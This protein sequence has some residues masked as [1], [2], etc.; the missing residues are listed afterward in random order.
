MKRLSKG[1]VDG[2]LEH[3]IL[4]K[5]GHFKQTMN[6][7]K[8]SL[9][10]MDRRSAISWRQTF[11]DHYE[12][13]SVILDFR[14]CVLS[15]NTAFEKMFDCTQTDLLGKPLIF[16]FKNLQV[17]FYKV[18]QNVLNGKKIVCQQLLRK[19]KNEDQ[20]FPAKLMISPVFSSD[21]EIKGILLII[22]DQTEID[23]SKTFIE[24]QKEIPETEENMLHDITKHIDELIILFDLEKDKILYTSPAFKR[25]F[26]IDL[27]TLYNKPILLCKRFNIENLKQLSRFFK[28]RNNGHRTLEFKATDRKTNKLRWF[29]F[30]I[31]PILE[32]DGTVKKHISILRD[33][34]ELKEKNNQ[35]KQLDQ[36]GAIGQMAAGI[37]H[38]I[39]NPLTT[40]KGFVQLLSEKAE[41]EYSD[42]IL[43][44][45]ERIEF[46]M[47]EILMLAKP[48]T[49]ISFKR[50]NL[51]QIIL[52]VISF[53]NPEAIIHNVTLNRSL[54]PIP[55][56]S[57]EAKQIKQVLINI[58]KNAIEAM[59]SG[60]NIRI[61]TYYSDGFIGMDI[62]DN[63]KGIS[64]ERLKRLKE[65]FY[66]DKEKGTGLGL[67][68]CYKLIEDH[69]GT[70]H[71]TS[72]EGRGT[73]VH[74]KLPAAT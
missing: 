19:R 6:L 50:K 39:K 15:M 45:L 23:K 74:I 72:E 66:T 34:T 62:I 73:C 18:V 59:P 53:M 51:N 38:E 3:S 71:F 26:D 17:E 68:I 5:S 2:N 13:A 25:K 70:I 47:G 9:E 24:W 10:Y 52:E 64:E 40:I 22:K 11:F 29:L 43:S 1:S 32:P 8:E 27:V 35:I 48:Q 49:N 63:G 37:A 7:S 14:G 69:H 44:E 65:P 46:I 67:M 57:C 16:P 36:L 54:S 58:I 4:Q 31:T 33:I 12:E 21:E 42:I 61:K 28:C 55:A 56:V 30:E 20:M 41:S 60:G